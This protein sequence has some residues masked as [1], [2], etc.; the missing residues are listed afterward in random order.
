M[1]ARVDQFC[2]KL[3]DR[4]NA[5]EGRLTSLKTNIEAVPRRAEKAVRGKL[6]EAREKLRARK[7]HVEQTCATLKARA[8][9]KAT[10]TDSAI[11]Q[12]EATRETQELNPRADRAEAYAAAA[13]DHAAASI[14]E[15]EDAVL[16]AAVARLDADE[17]HWS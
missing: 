1:S 12:W 10:E 4:L 17:A 6:D 15:V 14:D 16:Y 11:R 13:M 9:D 5:I 3:R 8:Q 2:D 7:E